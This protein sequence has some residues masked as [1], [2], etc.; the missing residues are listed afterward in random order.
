MRF[1]LELEL[2]M[3]S[4]RAKLKMRGR[5]VHAAGTEFARSLV[6][7]RRLV[8]ETAVAEPVQPLIDIDCYQSE[9]LKAV[10]SWPIHSGRPDK[11]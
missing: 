4:I 6:R 2:L 7:M 1:L 10:R 11:W 8:R 9:Q 5:S 3:P